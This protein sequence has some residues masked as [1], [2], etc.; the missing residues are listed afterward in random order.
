MEIF[1]FPWWTHISFFFMCAVQRSYLIS[2]TIFWRFFFS[3]SK[4]F[5]FDRQNFLFWAC[6]SQDLFWPTKFFILSVQV[7]RLARKRF[8]FDRQ[9]F[10]FAPTFGLCADIWIVCFNCV[11]LSPCLCPSWGAIFSFALQECENVVCRGLFPRGVQTWQKKRFSRPFFLTV[12][13]D[14]FSLFKKDIFLHH[15]ERSSFYYSKGRCCCH[16]LETIDSFSLFI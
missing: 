16:L 2:K 5:Y 3:R 8:Y 9:N 1:S 11:L 13:R 14:I 10:L 15:S 4:R 7:S 6:K 12:H